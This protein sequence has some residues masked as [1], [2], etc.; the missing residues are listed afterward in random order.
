[1]VTWRFHIG[2]VVVS[3]CGVG[4]ERLLMAVGGRR[5][6]WAM[7]AVGGDAEPGGVDVGMVVV[8]EQAAQTTIQTTSTHVQRAEHAERC[9]H[10]EY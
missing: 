4:H 6:Q 7:S 2:V 3:G 8:E 9:G 5:R 1:M 10:I